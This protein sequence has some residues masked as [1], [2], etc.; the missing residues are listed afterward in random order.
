VSVATDGTVVLSWVDPEDVDLLVGVLGD[1][2]SLVVAN[3]SPVPTVSM[4]P[5][6]PEWCGDEG[7]ID[8]EIS[9]SGS[10]FVDGKN[11]LVA[12]AGEEF[13][14]LFDNL[15]GTHNIEVWDTFP[16][17]G[18]ELIDGTEIATGP[19]QQELPLGPLDEA[20][21]YFQCVVHSSTMTGTLAVVAGAK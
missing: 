11:C 10:T 13:T 15:D 16:S 12:P 7:V 2:E 8:L 1:P 17:E 6:A 3:P 14:I 9:G 18:G 19:I 20:D 5:V 4:A 21:Y